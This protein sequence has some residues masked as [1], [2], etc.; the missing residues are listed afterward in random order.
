M[1]PT[2]HVGLVLGRSN[3]QD[4]DMDWGLFEGLAAED[5]RRVI[6]AARR[7]RFT[8]NEVLFHAEDPAD[9]LHLI[10]SGKVAVSHST[11]LG[12]TVTVA[13]LGPGEA[14]GEMALL[15]IEP[16][17]TATV[18][19]IE[20]TETMALHRSDFEALR[21]EHPSVTDVL[22]GI[23]VARVREL[24]ERLTEALFV[25]ADVRVRRRLLSL[26]EHFRDGPGA[27][28]I[29]LG[30]EELAELAGT[31]RATVNRVLRDEQERGTVRLGRSKVTL[32]DTDG[33][34]KRARG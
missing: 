25:G 30:Q 15:D 27:P 23:L 10:A 7:R 5:V 24:S 32:V 2:P 17:R 13:I 29:P 19:A 11:A 34:A 4:L 8:R 31:T 3:R 28:V 18:T 1:Q 22:V 6:Q 9:T 12:R 33:L 14:V 26:A 16:K 20:P 21:R